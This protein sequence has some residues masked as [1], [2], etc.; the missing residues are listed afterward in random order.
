MPPSTQG[1]CKELYAAVRQDQLHES[2]NPAGARFTLASHDM[3]EIL[4]PENQC[5]EQ[6]I[7]EILVDFTAVVDSAESSN[8]EPVRYCRASFKV[9][10][11]KRFYRSFWR[12]LAHGIIQNDRMDLSL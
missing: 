2:A 10:P 8:Y 5:S 6:E 3:N 1:D 4:N 7:K 12:S 9:T 11:P